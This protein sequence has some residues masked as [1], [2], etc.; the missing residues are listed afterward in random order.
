MP[1]E[2]TQQAQPGSSLGNNIDGSLNILTASAV[3]HVNYDL[4]HPPAVPSSS[5]NASWTRFVCISDTHTR[6]FPVPPG[7]VLLHAGDLTHTG[8]FREFRTTVEWLRGLPHATK[9]VIA[10]NHDLSLD[11]HD[12]WYDRNFLGWHRNKEDL[13]PILELLTGTESKEA[14][15][16]Y[17]QDEK[18]QFQAK[19]GGKTW[20]VYGSPWSPEFCNWGFNYDRGREADRHVK[21]IPQ[22]D[23]LLTHGPPAG[24]LDQT[25][26]GTSVGCESLTARLP[27]IRPLLHV[28]GHIHEA[29]GAVTRNWDNHNKVR[30]DDDDGSQRELLSENVGRTGTVHVNAANWPAGRRTRVPGGQGYVSFGTGPFQP[31]IVDIME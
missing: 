26:N 7:D 14:G 2:S 25:T 8:L 11:Q 3:V 21:A 9:I 1:S 19:P 13:E 4:S 27:F 24:I 18:Y 30:R 17:L 6:T 22:V 23:I 10:G 16:V 12:N 31:V 5:S 28:F 20:S 15:L 29:H